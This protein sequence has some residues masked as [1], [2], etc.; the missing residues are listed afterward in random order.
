MEEIKHDWLVVL[1]DNDK[2]LADSMHDLCG[3]QH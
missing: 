1:Y 2:V 3:K